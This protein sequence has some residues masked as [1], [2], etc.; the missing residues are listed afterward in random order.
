MA[1]IAQQGQLK[2]AVAAQKAAQKAPP[3]AP[4]HFDPAVFIGLC[5]GEPGDLLRIEQEIAGPLTMRRA[6][7]GAPLRPLGLRRVHASSSITLLDLSDD[8]KSLT[9]THNNDP[10]PVPFKRLPDYRASAEERAALA[11]RYYSDELDAAWTLTDQKEGLVL[12][13]TGSGGAA[14]AGVKPD[15]LEGPR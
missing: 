15:L 12:K 13:G 11:G 14:L 5:E 9:L 1:D 6:G 7:G 3:A 8:G 4:P 10:K 2:E